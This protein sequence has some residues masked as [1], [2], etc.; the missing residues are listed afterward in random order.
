MKLGLDAY[1]GF[2]KTRHERYMPCECAC[3]MAAQW[4]GFDHRQS[5]ISLILGIN[6]IIGEV[7]KRI[8]WKFHADNITK[9]NFF[10]SNKSKLSFRIERTRLLTT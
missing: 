2:T 3:V 6:W 9:K 4:V 5:P 7:V 1:Y 10:F 8:I